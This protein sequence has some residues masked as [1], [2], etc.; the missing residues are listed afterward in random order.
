MKKVLTL[1]VLVA[2]GVCLTASVAMADSRI[3]A[4]NCKTYKHVVQDNIALAAHIHSFFGGINASQSWTGFDIKAR[5]Q[6]SCTSTNSAWGTS[7]GWF[8]RA[9]NMVSGKATIYYRDPG[10]ITVRPI[11]TDLRL[12]SHDL[13]FQSQGS[14]DKLT[15]HF[16]N[17][18]KVRNGLPVLDSFDHESH[19][20]DANARPCP[21][22][23]PYRIPRTSY[24]IDWPQAFTPQTLI[25][26]GNGSWGR[27]DTYM[28]GDYLS[29]LQDEF[30]VAKDRNGDGDKTDKVDKALIDLC[31]NGVPNSTEVAHARCGTEPGN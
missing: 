13:V 29:A 4:G 22:S 20:F 5:N 1:L 6:T 17:C 7:S 12:L 21:T 3:R 16:G 10:D 25:S 26:M 18:L 11:P 15:I 30:N 19:V 9:Q 31:L 23:H 2:L 24:L 14:R 28:H 8:P 27:A